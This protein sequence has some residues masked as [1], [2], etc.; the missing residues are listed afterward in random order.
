MSSMYHIQSFGCMRGRVMRSNLCMTASAS[1]QCLGDPISQLR[2]WVY[3]HLLHSVAILFGCFVRLWVGEWRFVLHVMGQY[4][5][6]EAFVEKVKLFVGRDQ[7]VGKGF[8]LLGYS[9]RD[10]PV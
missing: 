3:L 8:S 7:S 5:V 1:L 2:C 10:V 6:P 9:E 4:L